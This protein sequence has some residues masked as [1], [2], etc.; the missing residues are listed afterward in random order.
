MDEA[1]YDTDHS[2]S[3]NDATLVKPGVWRCSCGGYWVENGTYWFNGPKHRDAVIGE[4][5]RMSEASRAAMRGTCSKCG[6]PRRICRCHFGT[7]VMRM[8][9]EA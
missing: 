7:C 4:G 8:N 9:D 3:F 2:C 6:K 1:K 5:P